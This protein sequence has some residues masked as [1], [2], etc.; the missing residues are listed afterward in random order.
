M[1]VDRETE[2]CCRMQVE[3]QFQEKVKR[4]AM[5][6]KEK[7]CTSNL[8]IQ[9]GLTVKVGQGIVNTAKKNT[10]LKQKTHKIQDFFFFPP[11]ET[12]PRVQEKSTFHL[13][14]TPAGKYGVWFLP[15]FGD[16]PAQPHNPQN[17]SPG[18]F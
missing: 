4:E 15:G 3:A 14:M 9:S 16:E 8:Q 17:G 11:R 10:N 2:A 6:K 12:S 1:V 18:I 7:G 13:H 5:M